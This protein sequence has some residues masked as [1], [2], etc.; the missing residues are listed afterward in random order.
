ML[1]IYDSAKNE[2]S[3][4]PDIDQ[5]LL[6][7]R[8]LRRFIDRELAKRPDGAAYRALRRS[9][10]PAKAEE[11]VDEQLRL[12]GVAA[13]AMFNR[14]D[15][16]VLATDLDKDLAYFS[17]ERA[18]APEANAIGPALLLLGSFFFIQK[19]EGRGGPDT[20]PVAFEFLHNTFGEFLAADFILRCL[21]EELRDINDLSSRGRPRAL[22]PNIVQ[23]A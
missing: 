18:D 14:Q 15:T 17:P 19:S 1:A 2:L 10:N 13:I 16:K 5:T 22:D 11:K 3:S 4:Q 23:P 8:L 21:L 7:D 9:G 20:G 6:Y 12:L